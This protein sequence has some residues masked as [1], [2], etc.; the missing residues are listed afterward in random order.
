M[1]QLIKLS[2][3]VSRYEL[4]LTKYSNQ[5]ARLKQ[6]RWEEKKAQNENRIDLETLRKQFFQ[7][8]FF[9]QL[10]WASSTAYEISDLDP[11]YESDPILKHLLW[12]L[13]DTYLLMYHPVFQF[14]QAPVELEAVLITPLEIFC[15]A[16]LTGEKDDIYQAS[17]ERFWTVFRGN[18]THKAL[19][20]LISL[21]RSKN[22]I[23]RLTKRILPV[24]QLIIALD[25]YVEF[26][27][28]SPYLECLDK[29]NVGAWFQEQARNPSPFKSPQIKA[30]R[31]LLN[32][33]RT[34]CYDRHAESTISWE[35]KQSD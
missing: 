13:P 18:E 28:E 2:D 16:F 1:A 31:L 5:F 33:T 7:D 23:D 24:K 10:R 17:R 26:L 14:E 11:K 8:L 20:P 12:K 35:I 29:R 22:I 32:Q 34:E 21:K 19:S 30:A 25:G 6:Q 9:Y 15:L 4:D 3:Y 27:P